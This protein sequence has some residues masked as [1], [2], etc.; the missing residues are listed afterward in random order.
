M[1]TGLRIE[2]LDSLPEVDTEL[3]ADTLYGRLGCLGC[4]NAICFEA[5]NVSPKDDFDQFLSLHSILRN[6]VADY[7]LRRAGKVFSASMSLVAVHE[8]CGG[9]YE[10][11]GEDEIKRTSRSINDQYGTELPTE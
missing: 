5:E 10:C 3:S 9:N 11:F 1:T 2:Q 6:G 7:E 4:K 8:V